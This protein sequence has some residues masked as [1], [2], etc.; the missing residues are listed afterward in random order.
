[1]PTTVVL[2]SNSFSGAHL[3]DMLLERGHSVIGISRSPEYPDCMLAYKRQVK[4]R[5]TASFRFHQIDLNTGL[6]E[7]LAII[8]TSGAEYVVNFA[9]QGEVRSSFEHPEHHYHTNT[10]AMVRLSEGLCDIPTL[11]RYVHIST[12]EVYGSMAEPLRESNTFNPSSPYAASKAGADLH[13]IVLCKTRDFPVVTIRSTNVYGP[14]QQLYRIIPRTAILWRMKQQLTLDG[15][16]KARKSYIHIRDVCDGIV[17]AMER[18]E[19]GAIYHLSPDDGAI[20][21]LEVVQAVCSAMGANFDEL[22]KVG[23]ERPG[24]DAKYEIDSTF[25]RQTLGWRPQ[26]AF[27]AGVQECVDWIN[28]DW[29]TIRTLPLGYE[30]KQ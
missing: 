9:A 16:G 15:G 21:I 20:S 1:M 8:R 18:G 27:Q 11:R 22:V 30:H 2:G 14:H 3:V 13:N 4:T 29:D 19:I 28:T 6:D 17:A 26:I 24:Q 12:P 25:A 7:I 5:G 10:L 23:P